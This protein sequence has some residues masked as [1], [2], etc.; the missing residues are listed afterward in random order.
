VA[1]PTAGRAGA[2]GAPGV[3]GVA[4][5]AGRG[6]RKGEDTEHKSATYLRDD[7]SDEIVGELPSTAPPVIGLN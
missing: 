7:Y 3:G 1:A 4:G 2:P 6:G 5:G